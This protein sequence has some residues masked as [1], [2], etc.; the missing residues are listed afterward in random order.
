MRERFISTAC[1]TR[2]ARDF[3]IFAYG[4]T[5]GRWYGGAVEPCGRNTR[6]KVSFAVFFFCNVGEVESWGNVYSDIFV[7]NLNCVF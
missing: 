1:G 2:R 3:E 7:S 5:G 6:A 4:R